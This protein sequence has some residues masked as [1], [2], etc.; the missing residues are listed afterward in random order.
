[1]YAG[2]NKLFNYLNSIKEYDQQKP[3]HVVVRLFS[4]IANFHLHKFTED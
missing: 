3:D 1:M 4:N 2:I